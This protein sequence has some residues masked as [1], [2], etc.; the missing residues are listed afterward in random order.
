M[1]RRLIDITDLSSCDFLCG[2]GVDNKL[3]IKSSNVI[4]DA[5]GSDVPGSYLVPVGALPDDIIIDGVV[6]EFFD[7]AVGIWVNTSCD[8][9]VYTFD[10]PIILP[11]GA[12]ASGNITTFVDSTGSASGPAPPAGF[13]GSD[14]D[15]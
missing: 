13:G 4:L 10:G 5:T 11:I 9:L 8:P 7:N 3:R 1:P 14:G 2:V 15:R 6:W 12:S